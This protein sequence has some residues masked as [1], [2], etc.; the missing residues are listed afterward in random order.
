MNNGLFAFYEHLKPGSVKVKPGQ[1]IRKGQVIAQV[2]F[3]GQTTGPHLHFH[4]ADRNEPLGAEGVPFVFEQFILLGSYGNF[5][6]FGKR[7]WDAPDGEDNTTKRKERP[8][9]NSV[10]KFGN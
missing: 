2:G 1:R 8:G 7:R 5:E 9:P 3:T 6:D 10:I 4:V